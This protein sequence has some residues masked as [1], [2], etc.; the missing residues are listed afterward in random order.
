MS[1]LPFIQTKIVNPPQLVPYQVKM[2]DPPFAVF[3]LFQPPPPPMLD[4]EVYPDIEM[5]KQY[6]LCV[7][8]E[9]IQL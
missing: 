1:T 2:V 9:K 3:L 4:G 5:K 6:K 8:L 7:S